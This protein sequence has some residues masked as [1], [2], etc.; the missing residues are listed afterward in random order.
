ML[1][2]RRT[3]VVC[4]GATLERFIARANIAHHR[5]KLAAE[6][7]GAPGMVRWSSLGMRL[8]EM[9]Q[10]VQQQQDLLLILDELGSANVVDDY[11]SNSF[12]P[13]LLRQ[14]ILSERSRNDLGKMLVLCDC[15]HLF[16]S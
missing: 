11:I 7:D 12:G 5:E 10:D 8:Q 1:A 16:L 6:Q 15:E 9:M 13:M 14:Q 2:F 4:E 3:M